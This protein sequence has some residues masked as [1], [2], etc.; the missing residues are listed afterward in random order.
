[1]RAQGLKI[2]L[3]YKLKLFWKKITRFIK[4]WFISNDAIYSGINPY[5]GT[6]HFFGKNEIIKLVYEILPNPNIKILDVGPGRGIY[7]KLLKGKGYSVIDAVEVYQPY[8][9]KFNLSNIYTNVYNVDILNFKYDFYD[10]IV[11][12]DVLEHLSIKNAQRVI[13]FAQSHSKLIVVSIPYCDYQIG[14]QLDGSGD[15]KQY[16]L[17]RENFLER[18]KNFK[19]LI[20][21]DNIGIFY[22]LSA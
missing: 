16:D 1:M 17:T 19:I 13:D 22:S 5:A 3:V 21:N 15:H 7:N 9:V 12:G 20:D 6:S 8:I 10:L 18:Y 14:Q 2:V 4:I 11:F